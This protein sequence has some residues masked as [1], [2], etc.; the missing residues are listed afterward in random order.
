MLDQAT[1]SGNALTLTGQLDRA[2]YTAV[3]KVI[4]MAG[5]KWNKKAKCHLFAQDAAETIELLLLTGEIADTKKDFGQF[6]TPAEIA[7]LAVRNACIKPGMFVLEPNAGLGNLAM[8]VED[9]GGQT[10]GFEIDAQRL[11][12][13]KQR[14]EFAGGIKHMS[15][16]SAKPE[17]VFD[18]VVMNPPFAGQADIAHVTHAMG[19]LKPDGRLVAIMSNGVEFR[20]NKATVAFRALMEL[21]GG[22][23]TRLPEGAFKESG[24]GVNTVMV[25]MDARQ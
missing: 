7:K 24:T 8:A 23:I 15:F 6:D 9:V 12:K 2:M 13:A 14:C 3:A 19:F 11:W 4:E 10:A 21:H 17:P 20:T 22:E 5:G 1:I 18:R 25:S 16:L